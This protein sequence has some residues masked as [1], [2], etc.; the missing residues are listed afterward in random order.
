MNRD[1]LYP[2]YSPPDLQFVSGEGTWLTAKTGDRFLDFISG[3]SVNTLG[4]AHPDLVNALQKQAK[5]IWHLS[6]M[7][8]VPGQAELAEKYCKLTF[9]DQV[10]F[11]NSGTESV[12]CALKS[13]RKYHAKNGQAQRT[14]IIGFEGAFHGRTYA[15]VNAAGNPKYLEGFGPRLPGYAHAR[16][17]DLASVE[18]LIDDTVAA[19]IVEPIQ[20]EGGLR[21]GSETF[22]T[23]LRNLSDRHGLLLIYDEVQCGAGR[24]GKL[25]AHQWF[26]G[27]DPDIMATAKGVGGGFPFGM[28]LATKAV[29]RHMVPGT[30]GTTYGGNALAC[31]VGD[32][33]LS[34][35]ANPSFM[36]DVNARAGQLRSELHALQEAFPDFVTDVRGKG[37]LTG[38]ALSEDLLN[39]DVRNH[40]RDAGLLVGVAGNNTV[41]LAPPLNVTTAEIEHA[42]STLRAVIDR[43]ISS[44]QAKTIVSA[45]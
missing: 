11:T 31:A 15:S 29:A 5:K 21:A 40:A 36:S 10:F 45:Q 28:C 38:V 13:A 20:G 16:F 2:S 32:A 3:I 39:M 19:I 33:V 35:L 7:F 22:L 30:H 24:T 14:T 37:L 6:N 25:F 17:N 8:N 12:E 23:G 44:V 27:A 1:H 34:H 41:R 9:A 18:A 4:H 43:L 42:A 26:K